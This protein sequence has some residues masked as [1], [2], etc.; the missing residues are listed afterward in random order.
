MNIFDHHRYLIAKKCIEGVVAS[1]NELGFEVS[2]E[3][4]YAAC[5]T[6]LDNSNLS[7]EPTLDAFTYTLQELAK[8]RKALALNGL[9]TS[10]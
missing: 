6:A 9:T 10:E 3:E 7:R 8:A 1:F 4:A 2:S 5:R